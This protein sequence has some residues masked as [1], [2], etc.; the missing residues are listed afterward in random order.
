MGWVG[1]ASGEILSEDSITLH[2]LVDNGA[3]ENT[4]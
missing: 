4:M 1:L 2:I 3:I